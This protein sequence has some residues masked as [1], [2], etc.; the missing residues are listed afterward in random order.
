MLKD[1]LVLEYIKSSSFATINDLCNRFSISESTARRSLKRLETEGLLSRFHGGAYALNAWQTV[2]PVFKRF[3]E[4]NQKK[5]AIGKAAASL[6]SDD[7]TIILLGGSTIYS[8]CRFLKNKKLTV[9]TNS[10]L[11]LSELWQEPSIQIILLGGTVIPEEEEV[12]GPL[13]NSSIQ[14]VR[15]D[16]VFMSTTSFNAQQ[17]L[18]TK[19]LVSIELYR[20]CMETSIKSVCLADSTKYDGTG[21]GITASMDEIDILITDCGLSK[22][23][24]DSIRNQNVQVIIA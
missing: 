2:T 8:M 10:L 11:V 24:A 20:A 7:S 15:A 21:A 9:I 19:D 1:Q 18:L 6:V 23:A 12:C 3:Q 4:N 5:N 22:L 17:G 16:Y 14:L 13:T